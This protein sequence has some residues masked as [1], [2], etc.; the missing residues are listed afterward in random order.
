ML[1]GLLNS[2]QLVELDATKLGRKHSRISG[3]HSLGN[4]AVRNS[5]PPCL[6]NQAWE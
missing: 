4:G 5:A 2:Q 1:A 3:H 6:G